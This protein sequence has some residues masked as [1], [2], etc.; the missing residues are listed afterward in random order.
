[1]TDTFE[2]GDLLIDRFG[3]LVVCLDVL[4][5][6][7]AFMLVYGYAYHGPGR[8]PPPMR[9]AVVGLTLDDMRVRPMCPI[10]WSL[11]KLA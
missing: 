2:S 6:D 4:D 10:G 5:V 7:E 1:M 8:A 9:E 11:R 3:H